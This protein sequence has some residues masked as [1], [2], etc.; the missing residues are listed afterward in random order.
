MSTA[1][2]ALL[3]AL[4]PIVT[5]PTPA[6]AVP[7]PLTGFVVANDGRIYQASG[8]PNGQLSLADGT[9]TVPPGAGIS[10][11]RQGSGYLALFLIGTH[12]G[13]VAG[14]TAYNAPGLTFTLFGPSGVATP[15]TKISAISTPE[16]VY[17]SFPGR[18]GSV[19]TALFGSQIKP[20]PVAWLSTPPGLAPSTA[21]IAAS[22][23]PTTGPNVVFVGLDGALYSAGH[24]ATG[25]WTT[26]PISPAGV[27][28]P[29]GGVAVLSD[30]DPDRNKK[31][32]VY[33]GNDGTLWETVLGP[34]P[35]P[36]L[37][38]AISAAGVI[39]PGAELA[40]TPY[41]P[42]PDP[43]YAAVFF[44]DPNGA[45]TVA[46]N[47]GS[48]WLTPTPLTPPG[49]AQPGAALALATDPEY[50]VIYVGW[51]NNYQWWW[52]YWTISPPPFQRSIYT[53]RSPNLIRDGANVTVAKW[54]S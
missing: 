45:I 22:W 14:T 6:K 30:P 25:A 40:A 1:T 13:I 52:L 43:W 46:A 5:T 49:L 27:A 47:L 31:R 17:V 15:G 8:T 7:L 26:T 21:S 23:D 36:W 20:G 38:Q 10:A 33:A 3:L 39:N 24:I 41:G 9:V 29:G 2:A 35:E 50:P 54:N 34:H 48:G 42:K 19:Y 44:A 53:V 28:P 51:C 37:P 11:I 18:N 32:V 16:G 4:T 12:G